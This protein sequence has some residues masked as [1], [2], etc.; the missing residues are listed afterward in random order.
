MQF[1]ST[2][3]GIAKGTF[4]VFY[5]AAKVAPCAPTNT[6]SATSI[7]PYNPDAAAFLTL[8]L[9]YKASRT[10]LRAKFNFLT[11]LL[12]YNASRTVLYTEFEFLKSALPLTHS[13]FSR[14]LSIAER[15]ASRRLL[16]SSM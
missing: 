6:K 7:V 9:G 11:L 5:Q 2:W 8:L 4:W 15:F 10:V 14:S 16:L 12:G 13:S 3:T 1:H